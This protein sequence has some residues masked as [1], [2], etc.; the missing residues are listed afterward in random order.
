[1]RE[2]T[3]EDRFTLSAACKPEP[4]IPENFMRHITWASSGDMELVDWKLTAYGIAMFGHPTGR[5]IN[6]YGPSGRNGKGAEA[7]P[8]FYA[9]GSYATV[10]PR[11]LA[12]KEPNTSTR[13][14]KVK[15]VNK[16]MAVLF[17]VQVENGK[18]NLDD[19]KSLCGNGDPQNVEPKGK[20]SYDAVICCK[21]FILSND[22]IPIDSFGASEK[23]R[24]YLVPYNNHIKDKDETLE[25]R[26]K[27][28]YGKILNL[29]WEHAIKYYQNG[30]KMP[31]CAAI[32]K[33]TKD[34][35][36]DQD[37]VG[38]FLTDC[39][40]F[41]DESLVIHKKVLFFAYEQYLF[42]EHGISRPGKMGKFTAALEKKGIFEKV[43]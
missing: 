43:K 27:P 23:E 19:L 11:S 4:G 29:L 40:L 35:F 17:D 18:L 5:I 7:R 32:D 2:A 21:I 3:P 28:E 25:D 39:C 38:K 6:L 9:L 33:A 14:D 34:Y 8:I 30:R 13:F 26:F 16:R 37:I 20:P 12:I 15:L 10:L 22:K 41:F 24:F 31:P 36:D 42:R 1:M